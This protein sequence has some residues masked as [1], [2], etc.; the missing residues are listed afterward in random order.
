MLVRGGAWDKS[1]AAKKPVAEVEVLPKNC[2]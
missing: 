2:F 1:M